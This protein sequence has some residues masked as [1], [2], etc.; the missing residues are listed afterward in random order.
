MSFMARI[1]KTGLVDTLQYIDKL[2]RDQAVRKMAPGTLQQ[3]A[4]YLSRNTPARVAHKL[5][6]YAAVLA[7]ARG[8]EDW[9]EK[10]P[11]LGATETLLPGLA[12]RFFEDEITLDFM[13]WV[14]PTVRGFSLHLGWVYRWYEFSGAPKSRTYFG[15]TPLKL[16]EDIHWYTSGVPSKRTRPDGAGGWHVIQWSEEGRVSH[17]Y[18]LAADGCRDGWYYTLYPNGSL[19]QA[20]KYAG[21]RLAKEPRFYEY[22]ETET[23]RKWFHGFSRGRRIRNGWS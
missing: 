20:A 6:L 8:H 7:I 15:P 9:L 10:A 11:T 23:G 21:G 14:R 19:A 2:A 4:P 5:G 17:L 13:G 12:V 16:V 1:N 18:H 22:D 3:L